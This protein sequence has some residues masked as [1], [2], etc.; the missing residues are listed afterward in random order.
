MRLC[1]SCQALAE[2]LESNDTLLQL[3]LRGNSIG[4][5]GAQAPAGLQVLGYG[6]EWETED[7]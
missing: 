7:V 2:S 5:R 4:S 6:C 1:S 3:T